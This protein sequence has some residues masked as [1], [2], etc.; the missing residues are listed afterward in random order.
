VKA[1]ITQRESKD[2][3]GEWTDTL[4][5]RYVTYFATMGVTVQPVSNFVPNLAAV[6]ERESF[7][8]LILTGGGELPPAFY[9]GPAG[10]Q[11]Q[12]HRDETE[13]TLVEFCKRKGIPILAICRGM[14][15][16]NGLWGG[17]I[18]HL[19]SLRTPRPIGVDHPVEVGGE[20]WLVNQYHNDGV[21][22]EDLAAG[23]RPLAVDKENGVVEAFTAE[24]GRILALQWHPER[25]FSSQG[26]KKRTEELI[27]RFFMIGDGKR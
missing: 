2:V 17:R 20:E 12:P 26:A 4:E 8:G 9:C 11:T 15:Y 10:E 23:L 7:D 19:R 14:Q 22:L 27:R 18:S 13:R 24:A 3:H 25:P 1:L 5:A 6:L 16:V 21:Y